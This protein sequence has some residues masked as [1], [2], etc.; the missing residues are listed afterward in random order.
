MSIEKPMINEV[1]EYTQKQIKIY[2]GKHGSGLPDEQKDEV[3]QDAYVRILDAYDRIDFEGSWKSFVQQHCRGAVFDYIRRSS[4]FEESELTRKEQDSITCDDCGNVTRR[5]IKFQCSECG[6]KNG[7]EFEEKKPWRIKNRVSNLSDDGSDFGID[8]VLG[9]NGIHDVHFL[10]KKTQPRWDLIARM[11]SQDNDI[12]L[13]GK[14]L[15]GFSQTELSGLFR[16]TRERLTQRF[17]EFCERLDSPELI[18]SRWVAQTIFA[19]GLCAEFNM[20]DR[21][22]GFGWEYEAVD[23]WSQQNNYIERINPQMAFEFE[24]N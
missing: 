13:V 22:L 18:N 5:T 21:D 9:A 6:S 15:L 7:N 2:I 23:L 1:I 17:A 14:L 24:W 10:M 4:G 19:F 16:V 11:A 12:H 3:E 8:N 20:P